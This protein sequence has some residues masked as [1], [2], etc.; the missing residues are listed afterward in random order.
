MAN[1]WRRLLGRRWGEDLDALRTRYERFQR[2]IDGNNRT[3][4]LM[5]DAGEKSGGDYLFD[6]RYLEELVDNLEEAVSGVVYDLNAMTD[7]RYID[8]VESF[9]RIRGGVRSVLTQSPEPDTKLVIPLSEIDIDA[10]GS[11]GE[12]MASLGELRGTLG[13]LVPDGFVT[14]AAGCRRHFRKA[15]LDQFISARAEELRNADT[16]VVDTVAGQLQ[17]KIRRTPVHRSVVR[18]VRNELRRPE[19]ANCN[20]AV[21]SSALGE[22][23]QHSFAGQHATFLNCRSDDVVD[24][25]RDVLASLFSSEALHY[26]LDRGLSVADAVMP[27]GIL[28]MV[29]ARASGV[30]HTIDPAAPQRDV[31]VVSATYG[32][33]PTVVQ[34]AATVDRF[35]VS[36]GP[37]PRVVAREIQKKELALRPRKAGGI[38]QTVVD[39]AEQDLACVQDEELVELSRTALRIERHAGHHQEIEWAIDHEGQI[40]IL[41]ARALRGVTAQVLS[42]SDVARI[43]AASPVVVRGQGVIACRGVGAGRVSVVRSAEDMRDFPQGGVLVTTSASPQYSPLLTRANAVVTDV[44]SS[45]GHLATVA[46]ELRVPM[47]VDVQNATDVLRPGMEVTVDAEENVIYSGVI[48]ELLRYQFSTHRAEADFAEFQLLRR[49]LRRIA[50]LNLSDSSAEDFRA[51]SCETYHDVIRFAHEMA[52][53]ELVPTSCRAAS[54]RR[55]PVWST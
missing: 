13:L 49:L 54:R 42:G 18:A 35:E 2:L 32:L 7:G 27:V 52:V 4:E 46:R 14:T 30:I 6:Q 19:R 34:G 31:L 55:H 53:R 39:V 48:G 43:R 17:E 1:W 20:Y 10:V 33:G 23:G 51:R 16:D 15:G 21:R 45:T 11:V 29:H 12:K 38:E 25:Y 22:D 40:V 37:L 41:Q 5:G 47:L 50:P 44:G 9:E 28:A 26:R 36:R 24:A 8:L 3:L